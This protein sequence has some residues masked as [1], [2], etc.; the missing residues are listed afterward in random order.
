MFFASIM[1]LKKIVDKASWFLIQFLDRRRER[2]MEGTG[3]EREREIT[4]CTF[5]YTH[6]VKKAS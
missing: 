3:K 1:W 5:I 6:C 4:N 2:E